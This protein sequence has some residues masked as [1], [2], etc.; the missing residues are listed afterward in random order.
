LL[1]EREND[2]FGRNPDAKFGALFQDIGLLRRWDPAGIFPTLNSR[3]GLFEMIGH[4]PDAAEPIEQG[5]LGHG[6]LCAIHSHKTQRLFRTDLCATFSHSEPMPGVTDELRTLREEAG[7]T[8]RGLAERLGMPASS[9]AAYESPAKFKKKLLPVELAH[10]LADE[11][12]ER[13]VD[14]HKVLTLAGVQ[15]KGSELAPEELARVL[16]LQLIP[17]VD[18]AYSLG[19]GTLVDEFAETRMVPFR[20][21]WLAR[22]TRGR[23]ANVFL[24]AGRGDSMMPTI[25]DGDDVLVNRSENVINDQDRIWAVGYGELGMIKRVRRLPS[26]IFQLNSDNPSVSSIDATEDELFIVG[27]VI[28]IGRR[29]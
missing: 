9:Y 11:L 22:L 5:L 24:T 19:G 23:D 10:R 6:E 8:V 1:P 27:R 14:R 28:W 3:G 17:E 20:A 2:V 7:L 12:E 16:G 15:S 25:L 26:G 29:I 13:G 21:D 4:L 18:I